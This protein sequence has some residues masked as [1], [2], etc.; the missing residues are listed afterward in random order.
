MVAPALGIGLEQLARDLD[1]GVA[2]G[3]VDVVVLEEHGRRQDDVG[4]PR[5]L[6]QELLV[7]ADEQVV[8][9]EARVHLASSG[10]TA[11]GLVFWISSA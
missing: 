11:I 7:H 6:G 1:P 10:A 2:G 3:L 9:G 5:G 4:H 8:P